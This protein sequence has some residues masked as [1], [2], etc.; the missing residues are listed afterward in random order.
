[1]LRKALIYVSGIVFCAVAIVAGVI[2]FDS[3]SAP[4]ALAAG[5]SIPGIQTWN[6]AEL[7]PQGS[8]IARDGAR[9]NYRFY[10]GRPSRVVLLVH[11]STGSGV[12]MHKLAQAFQA[13]GA[14]VYA[15]ALRGHGGSGLQNGD[16]KYIG[17]LDDDLADMVRALE[18]DKQGVHRTLVG[19]SSGG[20]YALRIASS[21]QAGQFDAFIAISPYISQDSPTNKPNI[22][23][24]TGLAMPRILAL[25]L[26]DELGMPWFQGLPVVHFATVA[27]ADDYRTP[28]Y[29]F[30][31]I[32]SLQLGRD[33]RAVISNV[34]APTRVL[35]GADDELFNADQFGPIMQAHN[36][37]ISVTIIPNQGHLSMI[38][39]QNAMAVLVATW[40]ELSGD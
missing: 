11:G 26:L 2:A 37:R 23:G 19:F 28:V 34:R 8:I 9:L 35:V 40:R 20:G 7:P 30:R 31:L 1:M 24:W 12:E 38:A 36:P 16:V 39:D 22:G 14:S 15:I 10:P 33:W 3:P 5:N 21:A 6:F 25:S 4:P 32:S 27:K 29:S 13:S 17:Q 18:L